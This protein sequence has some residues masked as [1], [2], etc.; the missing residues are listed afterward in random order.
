M[1][2][3]TEIA[4]HWIES[5][6]SI[7]TRSMLLAFEGAHEKY[8]YTSDYS[9]ILSIL[10]NNPYIVPSDISDY[11]VELLEYSRSD[12]AQRTA[13]LRQGNRAPHGATSNAIRPALGKYFQEKNH[14]IHQY[15]NGDDCNLELIRDWMTE[16]GH[17]SKDLF[18]LGHADYLRLIGRSIDGMPNKIFQRNP[19]SFYLPS[20][21]DGV[22]K[23]GKNSKKNFS[24]FFKKLSR[25][26]YLS[27]I[28]EPSHQ[29]MVIFLSDNKIRI[30]PAGLVQEASWHVSRDSNL[31]H[32][33]IHNI[34]TKESPVHRGDDP[35]EELED[36]MN[37]VS[38]KEAEF[39]LFFERN[40]KFLLGTDYRKLVS[41]PMLV[42]EDE[43]NLIPDFIMI[44]QN[45][46]KP[47]VLDL[48]LSDINI[49]RHT[50]NRQGFLQSVMSARD[51]LLEY[52]NYF[53]SK[54][55]AEEAKKRF[56]CD[57][58]LPKICV[59]IGRDTS[60][61]DEYERRKIESRVSDIDVFTYDDIL[62]RAKQ[63]RTIGLL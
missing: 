22:G 36:L 16:M 49:A 28:E 51:Q 1:S 15:N 29:D 43:E 50:A 4:K 30:R 55:T 18:V 60:F 11:V 35:I 23:G 27:N 9:L 62:N 42:R 33:T 47:Q 39:Q 12:S 54:S 13:K 6:G 19:N 44:P 34:L 5:I 24:K 26:S 63:C 7:P 20:F 53:S 31:A 2:I 52:R 14:G 57:I 40:P 37:S 61:A 17:I 45:F 8:G 32:G 48:K 21:I 56:G 38:A 10:K 58:Y 41:Q 25:K 59:V 3:S 46:A